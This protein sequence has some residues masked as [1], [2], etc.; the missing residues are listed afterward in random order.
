MKIVKVFCVV[1]FCLVISGCSSDYE[2]A[3]K[4]GDAT[5]C[6]KISDQTQKNECFLAVAKKTRNKEICKLIGD[7]S[8]KSF[9]ITELAIATKDD[10]L[11]NEIPKEDEKE[12]SRCYGA[13]GKV[14]K[15]IEICLLATKENDSGGC[16]SDIAIEK[17]DEELC[18]KIAAQYYIEKCFGTI[19]KNKDDV[20]ICESISIEGRGKSGCFLEMAKFKRDDSLC[21][22]IGNDLQKQACIRAVGNEVGGEQQCASFGNKKKSDECYLKLALEQKKSDICNKVELL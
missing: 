16:I 22:K 10:Q 20:N 19:A 21:E 5:I 15:K 13:V 6:K 11:C 12:K 7:S 9:C 14:L 4:K 17:N 1:I 8:E 2:K 18:R 3:V